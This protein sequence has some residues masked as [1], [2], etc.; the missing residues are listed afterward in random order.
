[1]ISRTHTRFGSLIRKFG[2]V[3]YNHSA[4]SFDSSL[5]EM[6]AF[7]RRRQRAALT[8]RLVHETVN[9]YTMDKPAPLDVVIFRIPINDEQYMR[10]RSAV[11]AI[12]NDPSYIY[13]LFSVLSY[14]LTGGF[15][16]YKA[17]SCIEFTMYILRMLGF[18]PDRPLYSYKPD[19]LLAFLGDYIYYE[20][21]LRDYVK[22]ELKN[23]TEFFSP[24]STRDIKESIW[25]VVRL[26]K[27]L[28][29]PIT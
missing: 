14:P 29:I 15:S 1:M 19:D 28:F 6:Y 12:Y 25:N 9:R 17:F 8:G 5:R 22:R 20:G 24:L 18:R 16:T 3:K 21:D 7:A 26:L 10:A 11:N 13:N 4:I 2:R 27:R 23:D